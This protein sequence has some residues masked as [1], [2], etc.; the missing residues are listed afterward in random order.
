MTE[1]RKEIADIIRECIELGVKKYIE[2][3]IE[4]K[5]GNWDIVDRLLALGDNDDV[6]SV[7]CS[8]ADLRREAAATI[9]VLRELLAKTELLAK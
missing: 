2:S 1:S 3:K 7:Q 6:Y 5:R 9:N 4:S 8:E